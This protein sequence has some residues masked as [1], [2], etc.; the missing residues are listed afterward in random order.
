MPV[1]EYRHGIDGDRRAQPRPLRNE[2][3]DLW[4]AVE[5]RLPQ[6]LAEHQTQVD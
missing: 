1:P 4:Q 6:M 2:D 5:Q 3:R